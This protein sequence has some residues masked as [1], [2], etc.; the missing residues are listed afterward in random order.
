MR[1]IFI[2]AAGTSDDIEV[3]DVEPGFPGI[4][5]ALLG[6]KNKLVEQVYAKGFYDL[7]R[8][9][10][11]LAILMLV[12]EEGLYA[13]DPKVNV[14]ASTLYGSHVHKHPI[15]GDAFVV[16]GNREEWVDLP[17]TLSVEDVVRA[18]VIAY[19][20]PGMFA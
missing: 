13:E 4:N 11:P 9:Y 16:A 8:K 18:A 6:D 1:V 20:N 14:I 17:D 19:H 10:A 7:S 2:P 12:D 3:R 5:I 15:M